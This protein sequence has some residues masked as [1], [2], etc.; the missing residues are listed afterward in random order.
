MVVK[1]ADFGVALIV[2]SNQTS[3]KQWENTPTTI[4]H[5]MHSHLVILILLSSPNNSLDQSLRQKLTLIQTQGGL[6]L[7]QRD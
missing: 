6:I 3:Q 2:I 7:V 4:A 5:L 1:I